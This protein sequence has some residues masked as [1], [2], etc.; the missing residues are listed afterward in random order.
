MSAEQAA[1]TGPAARPD[2]SDLK[3]RLARYWDERSRGFERAQ[4][5]TLERQR[6][7]WL[8]FLEGALGPAPQ[9]VLDVGTGTGFLALLAAELGHSVRGLDLSPGMIDRARELAGERGLKAK[10]EVADAE[11]CPEP[12]G[13]YDRV[14]NRNVL[15]TLPE[16][17]KALAD[18]YRVLAPGGLLV[19]VDGDWFDDPPSYRVKRFLGSLLLLLATRRN[20]WAARRRLRRG[21]DG[22]FEKHLPLRAPGN[23]RRFPELIAQAGFEEVRL[24]ELAEIDA[25]EK[26][27]LKLAERLVQPNRFFAVTARKP[28]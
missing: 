15:W 13:A 12:D 19:V 6:R 18:W 28:G 25:A 9:R 8:S 2:T 10:F 7:A 27:R 17:D 21:Y 11:G 22:S 3:A 24:H 16:P 5:I 14:I 23:R 20:P 4:G 26:A 1:S